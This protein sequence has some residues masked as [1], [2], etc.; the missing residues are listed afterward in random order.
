MIG[1]L[2]QQYLLFNLVLSKSAPICV[3]LSFNVTM[4]SIKQIIAFYSNDLNTEKRRWLRIKD[5][6]ELDAEAIAGGDKS[7]DSVVVNVPFSVVP[8]ADMTVARSSKY[9]YNDHG[10]EWNNSGK[11]SFHCRFKSSP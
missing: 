11:N 6:L 2:Y 3:V 10:M 7:R 1:W 9:N 5:A 8:G 4:N